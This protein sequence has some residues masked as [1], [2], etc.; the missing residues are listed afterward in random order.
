[1]QKM[2]MFNLFNYYLIYSAKVTLNR[3]MKIQK[4]CK[5]MQK[6]AKSYINM[7]MILRSIEISKIHVSI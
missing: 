3:Q 2:H 1:M 6:N 4:K 7:I 5:K